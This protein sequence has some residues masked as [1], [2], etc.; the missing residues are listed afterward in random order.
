[1][2]K[3]I[4]ILS[5]ILTLCLTISSLPVLSAENTLH[6][7]HDLGD[8]R[9][10]SA[11][12][13][14][15]PSPGMGGPVWMYEN[16]G[17]TDKEGNILVPTIY[18][19][20]RNPVEGRALFYID[21]H[22][23]FFDENWNIV[24]P[25]IYRGAADFS[26]G[27]AVVSDENWIR[28]YI[29]RDG[30]LV[31]PHQYS[32]ASHFK[33][34]VAEVGIAEQGYYWNTFIRTGTIDK[35]GNILSPII[36]RH[37]ASYPVLKSQNMI[38]INDTT[39]DN[40]DLAYPFIN[41]QGLAYFPLTYDVCRALGIITAWA[42]ETGLVLS[43]GEEPCAPPLGDSVMPDSTYDT[44]ALYTGTLTINGTAY[45]STDAYYP[46]LFYKDIIYFPVLWRQGM[47]ALG[48]EY[49]YILPPGME[50]KIMGTMQFARK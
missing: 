14:Q 9:I 34:G 49:Q 15:I 8:Y 16:M 26:E 29:N 43:M 38:R 41:Y 44:A 31:V 12:A 47:E 3:K 35:E 7:V 32:T 45:K 27:L 37:E 33:N 28:G 18:H 17:V 5:L 4:Q 46:L 30:T 39:Y 23:G 19:E 21:G 24:I 36:Y 40:R 42:P 50:G 20:I 10:V 25:P 11:N 48:I 22:A 6:I 2:K 1:M 13:R